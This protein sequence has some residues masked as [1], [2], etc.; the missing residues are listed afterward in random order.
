M[1][2]G[3]LHVAR[4]AFEQLELDEV[5][6]VL[7]FCPPHKQDQVL[8]PVEDRLRLLETALADTPEFVIDDREA[9]REAPTFTIDTLHEVRDELG[10][11]SDVFFLVGGDSLRDLPKWFRAEE[12]VRT[13]TIVTVPRAPEEEIDDLLAPAIDAFAPELVEKLRSHVLAVEPRPISSTEIRDRLRAGRDVTDLVPPS[14][15]SLIAARRYYAG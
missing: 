8:L 14:V 11:A 12:I 10:G 15:A 13:F 6:F 3:H 7:A 4:A 5:R 1:H 2:C 9:R